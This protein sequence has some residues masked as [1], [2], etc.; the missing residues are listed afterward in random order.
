[1]ERVPNVFLRANF[2]NNACFFYDTI[3]K[4]KIYNRIV[5]SIVEDLSSCAF[6]TPFEIL[7]YCVSRV[8]EKIGPNVTVG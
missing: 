3:V 8:L 4:K 7:P 2:K 1:M 5:F 6:F